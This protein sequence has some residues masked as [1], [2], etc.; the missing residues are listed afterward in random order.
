MAEAALVLRRCAVISVGKNRPLDA[1]KHA[2]L[3]GACYVQQPERAPLALR[4]VGSTWNFTWQPGQ[5]CR[6]DLDW[7]AFKV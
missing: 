2:R 4:Q 3:S 6:D 7:I 5:L 1:Q